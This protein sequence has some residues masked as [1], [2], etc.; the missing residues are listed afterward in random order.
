MRNK[1]VLIWSGEHH[2]WWRPG[3]VGYTEHRYLAGRWFYEAA[4][5]TATG[6]GPEKKIYFMLAD[7]PEQGLTLEAALDMTDQ[8]ENK[9]PFTDDEFCNAFTGL[10]V[11]QAANLVIK[12]IGCQMPEKE[13]ENILANAMVGWLKRIRE[14]SDL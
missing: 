8:M 6:C 11:D 4:V 12:M 7:R 14:P 9:K 5:K 10:N 3:G 2:A 1:V 13:A